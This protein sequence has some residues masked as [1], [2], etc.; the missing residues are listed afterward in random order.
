[1]KKIPIKRVVRSNNLWYF[2]ENKLRLTVVKK[3]NEIFRDLYYV[4]VYRS[5][6]V[7]IQFTRF[8]NLRSLVTKIK[9][10]YD[11]ITFLGVLDIVTDIAFVVTE[12]KSVSEKFYLLVIEIFMH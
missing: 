3:W 6:N 12:I 9:K 10:K 8:H 11:Y 2:F 1:M 4:Q 7:T 5:K